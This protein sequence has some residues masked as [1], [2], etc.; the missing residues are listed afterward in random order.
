[1]GEIAETKSFFQT[2]ESGRVILGVVLVKV[3]NDCLN[4]RRTVLRHV[5]TNRCEVAIIIATRMIGESEL[6]EGIVRCE[7]ARYRFHD[8]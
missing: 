7:Y 8:G 5:V 4:I 1:M 2:L 6:E 3:R